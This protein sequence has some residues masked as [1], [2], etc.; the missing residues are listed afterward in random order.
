MV[1]LL[2]FGQDPWA[3]RALPPNPRLWG[4]ADDTQ[5]LG[6]VSKRDI[7]KGLSYAKEDLQDTGDLAIV[8]VKIAFPSSKALTL[9][10]L[11]AFWRMLHTSHPGLGPFA[12]YQLYFVLS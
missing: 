3:G 7:S 2:K 9:E 1:V 5:E 11:E 12:G 4:V 10:Q 8:K 6:E